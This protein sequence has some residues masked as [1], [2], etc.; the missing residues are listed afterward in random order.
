MKI[1]ACGDVH[2][3]SKFV[4]ELAERAVKERVDLVILTGDLTYF[5]SEVEGFLG[6]LK[7][8]GLKV[9]LI[10]GNHETNAT[11]NFFSELYDF[12][13]I[14]GH[15]HIHENFGFFGVGGADIGPNR[16]SESEMERLVKHGH[17]KLMD[18]V[19]KDGVNLSKK[20]LVAHNHLAGTKSEF[21]GISGSRSLSAAFYEFE[22]D[23]VLFSHIH[24]AAGME[25]EWRGVRLVN[26]CRH[27]KVIE[28]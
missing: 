8:K 1:L 2:G 21:S 18:K 23:L 15:Y 27:P 17:Q 3:D 20:I 5:E 22:P 28:I 16:T 7:D 13:N 26:V 12:K 4:K 14:H 24:E 9:L 6:I 25:D 10:P 19:K 11:A